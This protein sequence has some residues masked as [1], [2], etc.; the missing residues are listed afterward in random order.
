MVKARYLVD[1]EITMLELKT[2]NYLYSTPQKKMR[3]ENKCDEKE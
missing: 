2:T 1:I 3:V